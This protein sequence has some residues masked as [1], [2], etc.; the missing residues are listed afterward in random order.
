MIGIGATM[1]LS[2]KPILYSLFLSISLSA[3]STLHPPSSDALIV[4]DYTLVK[5][6]MRK[7]ITKQ[8]KKSEMTGLSVALIDGDSIV[9][10]EGFGYSDKAANKQASA[11]TRYRAGSV[12]KLFTA[13]AVMQLEEVG[14][15]DLDEP[16][17][18]YVPEFNINS[19]FGSI[20]EITLRNTLSHHSGLPD[21]YIDGMWTNEPESFKKVATRLHDYYTAYEPNTVFSYSNNG[22]SLAG[23]A[24][25]NVSGTEFTQYIQEQVLDTL[26]MPHSNF[27]MDTSHPL[28]SKSYLQ[29]D[30]IEEPGLRDLPAGGLVTN[31]ADLSKLVIEMHAMQDSKTSVLRASTLQRMMKPQVFDSDFELTRYFGIGFMHHP[32]ML[33]RKEEFIGHGGQTMGHSAFLVSVP[34]WQ[35]GVV[36]L[37]NSP[38]F[39][40]NLQKMA[41]EML[42]VSYPVKKR[43][44]FTDQKPTNKIPLPGVNAS[45]EGRYATPL[46]LV[47]IS[48]K[49]SSYKVRAVNQKLKLSANDAGEHKLTL[50]LFGFIPIAPE[51]LKRPTFHA[52]DVNGVKLIVAD[53]K[54]DRIVIATEVPKQ[55]INQA[56]HD[57]LGDYSLENPIQSELAMFKI[58]GITL[59]YDDGMYYVDI[60]TEAQ[61]V[62]RPISVEN[63]KEATFQGH[64]RGLGETIVAQPDGSVLHS[65]LRFTKNN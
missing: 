31:V 23:H 26:D 28:V 48:G 11:E 29:G 14:K 50:K 8:M 40:G 20:D 4:D 57:R 54:S 2:F 58:N 60:E 17:R 34:E 41:A 7:Y 33:E 61:T 35:L 63:E 51:D 44:P 62:R 42:K 15:L 21:S 19:R 65:G 32:S 36:I 25:E 12:S 6:Y 56:W 27:R 37:G 22:Y 64:S 45:F 18:A 16:L 10:T 53:N 49:P 30:Q 47:E 13:I 3:C 39:S 46:G 43:Q 24:V 55:A 1:K 9:W 38:D 59:G 5:D 52:R